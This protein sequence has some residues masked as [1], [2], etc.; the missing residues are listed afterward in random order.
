VTGTT[1]AG[2]V[3]IV[4]GPPGAGKSTVARLVATAGPGPAVHLP[5][6]YFYEWIVTGLIPPYLAESHRQN[7]IVIDVTADAAFG[8]AAGGYLVVLDG[9]IGPWFLPPFTTRAARTGIPLHYLIL[10]P[11]LPTCLARAQ[12]RPAGLTASAPIRQLHAQFTALGTLEPH[13]IDTTPHSPADTAAEITTRI[14]SDSARLV[15]AG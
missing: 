9:V 1:P 6:D 3:V 2:A 10:R 13:V 15:S 4:T 8:Y 14:A 5:S 7:E 12:S 11:D